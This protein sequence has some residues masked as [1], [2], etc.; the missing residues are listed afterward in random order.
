MP[1]I[2]SKMKTAA[3]G[4]VDV[5]ATIE[6]LKRALAEAGSKHAEAERNL[7]DKQAA[8][9]EVTVRRAAAETE[10][11]RA[12]DDPTS[13]LDEIRALETVASDTKLAEEHAGRQVVFVLDALKVAR[14]E[15]DKAHDAFDAADYKGVVTE[16][17]AAFKVLQTANVAVIKRRERARVPSKLPIVALPWAD[18]N[19][20]IAEGIDR[21]L[22]STE[23][24]PPRPLKPGL[25]LVRITRSLQD[26]A[27]APLRLNLGT[28]Q[29]GETAAFGAALADELIAR[30]FAVP[31]ER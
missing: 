11:L 24:Q 25:K 18:E 27:V 15:F 21:E 12:K 28:F 4:A 29:V 23:P 26:T 20:V 31:V 19:S 30:N 22:K 13:T 9:A 3:L 10:I 6:T 8:K 1:N 2:L 17:V 14:T 7:A 16:L 5:P